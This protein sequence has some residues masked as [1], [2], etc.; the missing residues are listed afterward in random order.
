MSDRCRCHTRLTSRDPRQAC[1][2]LKKKRGGNYP[3]PLSCYA[4]LTSLPSTTNGNPTT[5]T[6]IIN[7]RIL[8]PLILCDSLRDSVGDLLHGHMLGCCGDLDNVWIVVHRV[9]TVTPV[10]MLNR[11]H[12]AGGSV[13]KYLP[14]PA[15][16]ISG[17]PCVPAC[18]F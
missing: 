9:P 16:I 7:R 17:V 13:K 8:S 2:G 15:A 14:V 18:S 5:T 12:L 4:M 11:P 3:A 6:P 1:E 10:I